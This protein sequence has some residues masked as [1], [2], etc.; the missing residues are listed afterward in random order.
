MATYEKDPAIRYNW[1]YWEGKHSVAQRH[2]PQ[3]CGP[4]QDFR[5]THF[6][7]AY[8]LGFHD[9]WYDTISNAPVAQKAQ[10]YRQAVRL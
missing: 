10:K 8:G 6:D 9:G 7:K 1:G 4:H 3:W 2:W 5:T